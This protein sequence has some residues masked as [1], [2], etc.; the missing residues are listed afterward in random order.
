LPTAQDFSMSDSERKKKMIS[1]RLSHVEY[2][3]LKT[4]YRILGAR[5]ISD[6]ARLAIQR[7]MSESGPS[8]D[9]VNARLAG[10]EDRVNALESEVSHLREPFSSQ[11]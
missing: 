5:N 8:Q 7:M 1:L 10:L 6:L 4:Q 9:A 2:D 11:R 3:T